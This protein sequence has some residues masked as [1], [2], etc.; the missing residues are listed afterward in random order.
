M[1][2]GWDKPVA[3]DTT[4]ALADDAVQRYLEQIGQVALVTAEQ[5]V[6][7]AQRIE[8]GTAAQRQLE[9]GAPEAERAWLAA[10]VTDGAR[11]RQ[12]LI[13]ANLRLVVSIAKK[14]RGHQLSLLDLVQEG[15]IGLI[16]AVEKFDWRHGYRFSTYATWWIRQAVTRALADQDRVIRLPVH[17]GDR[18]RH[19]YR[20][21]RR[22]EQVLGQPPTLDEL[23]TTLG[24]SVREVKDFLAVAMRPASLDQPLGPDDDASIGMVLPT[25]HER[26]VLVLR[27][28]LA[29]GKQRTLAEVG[30]AF[31]LTRERVRQIE[32]SALRQLRAPDVSHELH[33]Y[34]E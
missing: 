34:L 3:E 5:E 28:G 16:R 32:A 2:H 1:N 12:E 30:A 25:E 23:A 15:N 31:G 21:M 8:R 26:Q 17:L 9:G 4:D 10:Q 27:Y 22:L 18:L 14:Y 29:D 6:L 7:L 19:V 20:T 33:R 11:A 24:S 13:E